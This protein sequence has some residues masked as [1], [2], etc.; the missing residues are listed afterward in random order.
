[1]W[2]RKRPSR[3]DL[4]ARNQILLQQN[5]DLTEERDSWKWAATH[6]AGSHENTLIRRTR[7]R[8]QA[9]RELH[10]ARQENAVRTGKQVEYSNR[11]VG[12]M[13]RLARALRACA[14][15]R[16]ELAAQQAVVERQTQQLF[17]AIGYQPAE[18][19]LLN[20]GEVAS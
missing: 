6:M 19:K 4:D 8:D 20:A 11:A 17:D 16:A 3:A 13:R 7:E 2:G 12:N 5:A 9:R 1:M 14:R 18:R 15:Y 10:E